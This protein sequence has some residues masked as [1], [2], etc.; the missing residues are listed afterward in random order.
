MQGLNADF[1]PLGETD[2]R[3]TCESG[4]GDGWNHYAHSMAWFR[5]RLYVGTT[6]AT[7]AMNKWNL[8]RPDMKPWP[9]DCPEDLYEVPRQAEIWEYTPETDSWLRV[10]Q[11][12]MVPGRTGDRLVPRYIGYRGITVFQGPQ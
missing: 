11:A 1:H 2:F 4:F 7:M 10:Y 8:P 3:L 9:V 12:P 6:R 5:N